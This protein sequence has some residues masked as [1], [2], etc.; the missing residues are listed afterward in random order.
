MF[1]FRDTSSAVPEPPMPLMV[2]WLLPLFSGC[3]SLRVTVSLSAADGHA[4]EETICGPVFP[5][6]V[7]LTLS[8]LIVQSQKLCKIE[9]QTVPL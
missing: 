3:S 2:Q 1:I 8:L 6:K 9:K 5:T 7:S 4:R